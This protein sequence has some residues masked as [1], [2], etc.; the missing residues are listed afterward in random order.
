MHRLV[1]ITFLPNPEGY[2]TVD[3][4]NE[5]HMNAR[6]CNLRWMSEKENR[7]TYMAN[8]G[9]WYNPKT[10]KEETGGPSNRKSHVPEDHAPS[11][12]RT[13]SDF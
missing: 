7:E 1:A 13:K 3:H 4:I 11:L 10:R 8:H 5:D 2:S 12:A 6:V 9:Y